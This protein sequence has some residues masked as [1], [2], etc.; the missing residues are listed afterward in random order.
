MINVTHVKRSDHDHFIRVNQTLLKGRYFEPSGLLKFRLAH[1]IAGEGWAYGE[2]FDLFLAYAEGRLAGYCVYLPKTNGV[3]FYVVPRYRRQG[4]ASAL[5]KAVRKLTGYTVLCAKPGF[6]GSEEFFRQAHIFV[7]NDDRVYATLRELGGD[8][9]A[10]L[11]PDE[12]VK[13][14]HRANATLKMQLH[15][16]LRK[17]NATAL[18]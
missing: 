15:H 11:P 5:V 8:N 10:L 14:Y 1:T 4:V 6:Q 12:F 9:Y 7:E 18:G 13:L 17:Q 16:A 3:E 2:D